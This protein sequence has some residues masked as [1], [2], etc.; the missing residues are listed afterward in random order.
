MNGSEQLIS[1]IPGDSGGIFY[2]KGMVGQPDMYPSGDISGAKDSS[3]FAEVVA[4]GKTHIV[5]APGIYYMQPFQITKRLVFRGIPGALPGVLYR[6]RLHLV[7]GSNDHLCKIT[8]TGNLLTYEMDFW[9]NKQN[10]TGISWPI[11]LEDDN[12]GTYVSA[13]AITLF[14]SIVRQGKSGGIYGGINRNVGVIQNKSFIL[15]N[16]GDG[17]VINGLDWIVDGGYEVGGNLGN[18]IVCNG[19]ANNFC[20]GDIYSSGLSGIVVGQHVRII[21]IHSNQINSNGHHGIDASS[22]DQYQEIAGQIQCNTFYTNSRETTNTYSD[23]SVANPNWSIVG[24]IHVPVLGGG[25]KP[26]YLVQT[27]V[28]YDA[29]F[30]VFAAIYTANSYGTDYTRD[31]RTVGF[32]DSKRF[33]LAGSQTLTAVS[34][35]GASS[36]WLRS[37]RGSDAVES[38]SL[39]HDGTQRWGAGGSAAVDVSWGR[40]SSG[41]LGVGTGNAFGNGVF[42]TAG[43]PS[44][45]AVGL[46][47]QIYDS[48]LS[49][50][51]WSNGTVWKDA[52]GTTV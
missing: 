28:I 17:L 9:G 8:T 2:P 47:V 35:A 14:N 29:P 39:D 44:A 42:S 43:R 6:P 11:F 21:Q 26:K 12:S 37:F 27:P 45:S 20:G 51:I 46:G 24:N 22:I 41:V 4:N 23:I 7:D 48:T 15:D 5:W 3:A 49:K 38:F 32:V 16:D 52:V 10:Q 31:T 19:E 36:T 13:N 1:G 18:G 33:V 50:P 34:L 25:S 30:K 40:R